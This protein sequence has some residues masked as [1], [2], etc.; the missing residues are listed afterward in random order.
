MR[1]LNLGGVELDTATFAL[2]LK[3]LS[4]EQKPFSLTLPVNAFPE[5]GQKFAVAAH[6]DEQ[7]N[8]EAMKFPD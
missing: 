6:A 8:F 2:L 1:M 7:P 5:Y 4:A 3:T